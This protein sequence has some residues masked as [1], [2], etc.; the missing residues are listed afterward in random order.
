MLQALPLSLRNPRQNEENRAERFAAQG[1]VA[2][3][4]EA[5]RRG[6]LVDL[7]PEGLRFES[8]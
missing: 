5:R 4:S 3:D 6:A 8:Q 2:G 1:G 7:G